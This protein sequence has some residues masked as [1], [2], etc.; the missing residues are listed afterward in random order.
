MGKAVRW[1]TIPA[2][3]AIQ[4]SQLLWPIM[5]HTSVKDLP[6]KVFKQDSPLLISSMASTRNQK[7]QIECT[8]THL[9][10]RKIAVCRYVLFPNNLAKTE[11]VQISHFL[12]FVL[13]SSYSNPISFPMRFFNNLTNKHI[14]WKK[15]I[16]NAFKGLF[17]KLWL[18]K[19]KGTAK[20]KERFSLSWLFQIFQI[21]SS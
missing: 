13:C 19:E 12:L 16:E 8:K 5:S 9:Q 7:R 17:Q 21:Q 6:Q 1:R 10:R 2:T 3:M 14:T 15:T 20:V 4:F 18:D 11:K